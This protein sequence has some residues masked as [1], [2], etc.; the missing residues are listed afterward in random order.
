MLATSPA[1]A[2]DAHAKPKAVILIGIDGFRWDI[3]DRFHTPNID[4]LARSGV[5]AEMIPVWPSL[6]Y[7]NF[8]AIATGLYPDHNGIVANEMFDPA[9][10]RSFR[11][12]P[13]NDSRWWRG[14]PFGR[15]WRSRA[16]RRRY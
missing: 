7:P 5:R 8:W 14:S 11:D 15:R 2:R 12:G 9:T 4:M 3:P 6:T 1:A 16:A 10:G 13:F